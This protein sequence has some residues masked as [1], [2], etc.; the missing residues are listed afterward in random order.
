MI[1]KRK[2]NDMVSVA[3]ST[4]NKKPVLILTFQNRKKDG[5]FI[6][7]IFKEWNGP[8]ERVQIRL[9]EETALKIA[10]ELTKRVSLSIEIADKRDIHGDERIN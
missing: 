5:E 8:E 1:K 9:T 7:E 3:N 2:I 4:K 10:R 6:S